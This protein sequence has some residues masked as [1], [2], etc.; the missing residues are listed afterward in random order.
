VTLKL[1]FLFLVGAVFSG[2][3]SAAQAA[4]KADAAGGGRSEAWTGVVT[5]TRTQSQSDHKTVERVSGRGKDTRNWEMKYDYKATVGVTE[6]PDGSSKAQASITHSFTSKESNTAVEKNSCD[7]GKTWQDMTGT[8]TSE[9]NI[10][11]QG[12]EEA[13]VNI[14]LNSDGTYSISVGVPEIDGILT[15]SETS[16]FSGQCKPKEG[17]NRTMPATPTKIQGQSLTSDGSHRIDPNE[18][19]R[20]SGSYSLPLPGGVVESITW[21]LQKH[22]VPLRIIDLKFEDM[23]YPKWD[24]W[25]EITEQTGTVDGNWV[26]IKATVFNASTASKTG[27]VYFKETYKGDKWDGA[28]PDQPLKD[29]TFTITLEAGESR[30]VEMLWDSSGYSWFDDGRPRLVQRIKAEIWENYKKVDEK[31]KNLKVRPKPIILVGGIWSNRNDF[32]IYQNLLTTTHSYD[33]KAYA[34]KDMSSQGRIG[35]EGAVKPSTAN[36]SVYENADNLTTYMD[37]TRSS[38]NAWHVDMLAHSTGGLVAR[39]YIHKQMEVLPDGYPVV[40]HL[41]MLGTPNKGVPCADSMGL[42]DAFKNQMQT[43]KELMP[44]EIA[45]F[46][47]Y[48]NQKK[49]TKFSA[50]AGNSIPILCASP[51]WNDGFVSVESA[52]YGVEDVTLTSQKHPDMVSTETFN[53]YVKAHVITGPRGTY[54]LAGKK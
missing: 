45:L 51:Q 30:E 34:V 3:S 22:A 46:N 25:H 17:K 39:L 44:E 36:R 15:G 7:R 38:F 32:E 43:A 14:G 23:K 9:T 6:G 16:T 29:Q 28:R 27:E 54:P 4:Q 19:N 13:N 10:S 42:N 12:K 48:V 5:Y 20:L 40:K 1:F 37:A 24:D 35:G 11:G 49:G 8:F 52:S 47:Q 26:K 50:M 18:P 31:T 53:G 33:W 2:F 41:M 21:N